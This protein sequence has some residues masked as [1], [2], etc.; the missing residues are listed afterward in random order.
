MEENESHV[1]LKVTN[2]FKEATILQIL[3]AAAQPLIVHG[4]KHWSRQSLLIKPAAKR[5]DT[6]LITNQLFHLRYNN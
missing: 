5:I 3:M 2:L 6:L 4:V 1:F